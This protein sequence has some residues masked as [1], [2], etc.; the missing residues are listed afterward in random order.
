MKFRLKELCKER[1]IDLAAL[2]RR[3]DSTPQ[4]IG[5]LANHPPLRLGTT[6]IDMLCHG[7]ECG[8]EE[9]I[10]PELPVLQR[11]HLPE[12]KK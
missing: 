10:V 11:K 1:G 2:A 12:R 9:L 3:C 6:T 7:L 4:W 5:K 8:V